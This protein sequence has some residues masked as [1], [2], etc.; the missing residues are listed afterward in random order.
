MRTSI[1]SFGLGSATG[2]ALSCFCLAWFSSLLM[3]FLVSFSDG[4]QVLIFLAVGHWAPSEKGNGL[5]IPHTFVW[6]SYFLFCIPSAVRP[7]S[8]RRPLVVLLS[9]VQH[10]YTHTTLSHT[11]TCNS[12]MHNVF[13]RTHT[14]T[15]VTHNSFTHTHTHKHARAFVTQ[16]CPTQLCHTHT[17]LFH[18][19][20]SFTH[21]FTHNLVTHTYTTLLHTQLFTHAHT[22]LFHT[23][24]CH[25]HSRRGTWGTSTS[26]PCR[27]RGTW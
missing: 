14:H 13:T 25:T 1:V 9:H 23:E 2:S 21:S 8:V 16:L 24:L 19:H 20:K 7:P 3:C 12:F 5:L 11:H 15:F 18:T 22:Q 26:P 17:R 6:G 4:F 10:C 27:R